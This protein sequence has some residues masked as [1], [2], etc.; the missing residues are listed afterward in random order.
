MVHF[1]DLSDAQ[2]RSITVPTLIV[3][4]DRDVMSPEHALE[5]H[6]KMPKSRLAIVPGGHG[7]YMGEVTTLK[8][9]SSE[10]LLIV[11]LLLDFLASE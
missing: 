7:E 11:P 10:P 1:K 2:I 4:G 8:Q 3:A 6:H 5:M 9:T